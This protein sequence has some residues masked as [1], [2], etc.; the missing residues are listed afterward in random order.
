MHDAGNPKAVL[1][2][3]R[4]DGVGRVVGGVFRRGD[5]CMPMANSC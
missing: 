4:K 2:D 5:T 1:C 3:S